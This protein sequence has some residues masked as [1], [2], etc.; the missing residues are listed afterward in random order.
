M[1]VPAELYMYMVD[2]GSPLL[3]T[4]RRRWRTPTHHNDLPIGSG[5]WRMCDSPWG[6]ARLKRI[7]TPLPC[8]LRHFF[9][10]RDDGDDEVNEFVR[11]VF[12][13]P[14]CPPPHL[15]HWRGP[16]RLPDGL[17]GD[18]CGRY[19]ATYMHVYCMHMILMSGL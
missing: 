8:F 2:A 13:R 15:P 9:L 12:S 19:I 14:A 18:S 5:L 4:T 11:F 6:M 1:F 7:E 16:T 3:C 10:E 17:P